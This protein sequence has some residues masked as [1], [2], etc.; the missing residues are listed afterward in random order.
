[1]AAKGT[2]NCSGL[3][4]SSQDFLWP[5]HMEANSITSAGGNRKQSMVHVRHVLRIKGRPN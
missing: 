1:M 2:H 3:S 4:L 5:G